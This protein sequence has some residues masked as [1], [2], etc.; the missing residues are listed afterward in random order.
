M[1]ILLVA[2][3]FY[4][5]GGAEL[6]LWRL[7]GAL[8]QKGHKIYVITARKGGEVNFEVKDG[9]EIYRPFST[10]N[11]V[12]RFIFALRLYP[13]LNKWLHGKN[14]NIVYNLGFVP[15]MPVTYSAVKYGIPAVTMLSHLCGRKWFKLTMPLS[16]LLNYFMEIFTIRF[17]K[18]RALVVQCHD[19]AR[20]V[21]PST[22]AEIH[23]ICNTFLDPDGVKEAEENTDTKRVRQTLG[24]GGDELFLLFVG[25]LI[26]TKNVP[27]LV[28]ILAGWRTRFR[29]VLAGEG[30]ERA[31]IE[32]L[33]KQLNLE[34]K[35]ILLGQKPHDETL[36]IIK[37]CDVLLLPSICEQVPNVVLEALALGKLVLATKVGGIP[38]I[39]SAN[40]HLIDNLED[41]SQILEGGIV[42]KK[43]DGII[44]EYSLDNVAGQYE[45]LFARLTGSKIKAKRV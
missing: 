30:P 9:V 5:Y 25:A 16:A 10:G 38:E 18:H 33:I 24:I 6:S 27:S 20:K 19:S 44:E 45:R 31:K 14:V 39:K 42:A 41:I 3:H 22:Q 13:Y 4:P 32:G 12:R 37:T 29:L 43:E 26:R 21:A 34:G 28:R 2:E 17:G 8:S 23:V 36:A 15:T 7:C 1:N 40:L 11:T 35:V